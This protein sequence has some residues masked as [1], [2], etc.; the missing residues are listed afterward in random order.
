MKTA[1]IGAGITGLSCAFQLKKSGQEFLV[2]E[3]RKRVGG[4]IHTERQQGF[5]VEHVPNSLL[6]TD[7]DIYEHL[8]QIGIGEEIVEANQKSNNRYIVRDGKL[9]AL[10]TSPFSFLTTKAF[11]MG[12][13]FRLLREFSVPPL[14]SDIEHSLASFFKQRLGEEIYTYAADPFISGIYAGDP[15]KLS[16]R[17]AF[18]R[19]W[20]F[21]QQHGSLLRGLI[22]SAKAKKKDPNFI[23]RQLV[24]FKDGMASL[25]RKLHENVREENVRLNVEIEAIEHLPDGGWQIRW[26][27]D[28]GEPITDNFQHLVLTNPA[29]SLSK[30]PFEEKLQTLLSPLSEM[31]HPPIACAALGFTEDQVEHALD[32][33]GM[34]IPSIEGKNLLG[35]IFTTTLFPGRAPDGEVLLQCFVG[36]AKNP[37]IHRLSRFDIVELILPELSKILGIQGPPNFIQVRKWKRS[38][39]QLNIGH[40]QYLEVLDSVEK[41]YP[42]LSFVGNYRTGVSVPNCLHSGWKAALK[43]S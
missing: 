30:I 1:I 40:D 39:P 29:Y 22:R 10:P 42:T 24:S 41:A 18:P 2:L 25:P 31:P 16:V 28:G 34:L 38:I 26:T 9:T 7:A 43:I 6:L 33:F 5:L 12:G 37:I 3:K 19:M 13:K 15:E 8:K 35:S 11:S 17:H 20:D 27:E 36:G 14:D 23:P 4:V 32:G 21:E